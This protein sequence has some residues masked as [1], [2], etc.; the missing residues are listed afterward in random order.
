MVRTMSAPEFD[1]EA[2]KAF[3]R[4][5]WQQVAA[6]YR[7]SFANLTMQAIEP[8]LEAVRSGSGVRLLDVAC[9]PGPLGFR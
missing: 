5:G 6:T 7:E 2:F 1:A 3:E 8:L 9:G 4:E